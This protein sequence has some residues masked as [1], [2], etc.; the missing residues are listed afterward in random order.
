MRN[1]RALRHF[2]TLTC[3]YFASLKRSVEF[4]CSHSL[5]RL[6]IDSYFLAP[7]SMYLFVSLCVV[8]SDG[9]TADNQLD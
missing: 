4:I 9:G 1:E 8:K 6:S 3:F 7:T 2:L 5:L